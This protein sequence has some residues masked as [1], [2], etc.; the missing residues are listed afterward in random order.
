MPAARC[1]ERGFEMHFSLSNAVKRKPLIQSP[2]YNPELPAGSCLSVCR[3][4]AVG[5]KLL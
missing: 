1:Q 3:F 4:D 2:G 5:F